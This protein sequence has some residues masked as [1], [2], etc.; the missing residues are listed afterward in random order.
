MILV[1][2][3]KLLRHRDVMTLTVCDLLPS[4]RFT[5]VESGEAAA[6]SVSDSSVQASESKKG[7]TD[8]SDATYLL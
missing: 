4:N 7:L 1:S 5:P 8:A 2:L 6:E 3:L